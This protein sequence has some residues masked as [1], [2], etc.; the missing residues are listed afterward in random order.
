[1]S[2]ALRQ[3]ESEPFSKEQ[4]ES[5]ILFA[6]SLA[7]FNGTEREKDFTF[8]GDVSQ[9]A[10]SEDSISAPLV[11]N[12][13]GI[14]R[15]V[16]SHAPHFNH[17]A[18]AAEYYKIIR[19]TEPKRGTDIYASMN[20]MLMTGTQ[21]AH[22]H[23]DFSGEYPETSLRIA[24]VLPATNTADSNHMNGLRFSIFRLEEPLLNLKDKIIT[25][26][27]ISP[28]NT[29]YFEPGHIAMIMFRDGVHYFEGNGLITSIH[30]LDV[31]VNNKGNTY[32]AN[33]V[34]WKGDMTLAEQSEIKIDQRSAV[35]SPG[36][37]SLQDVY[38]AHTRMINNLLTTI[39]SNHNPDQPISQHDIESF[40]SLLKEPFRNGPSIN[41]FQ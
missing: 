38:T 20:A 19:E 23:P 37:T 8:N 40:M 24:I 36:Y 31:G 28:Q 29:V 33:T 7:N 4:A 34:G 14:E 12:L 11:E 16:H 3:S 35:T 21:L 17:S 6:W 5:P 15:C 13:S 9:W 27:P 32:D 26:T 41:G 1:M 39:V 2:N 30:P 25:G 10:K 18:K 22:Y